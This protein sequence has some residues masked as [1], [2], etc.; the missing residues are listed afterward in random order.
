M[1]MFLIGLTIFVFL[2]YFGMLHLRDRADP[3]YS[4]KFRKIPSWKRKD[5]LF[6]YIW[7]ISMFSAFWF[8]TL[9]ALIIYFCYLCLYKIVFKLEWKEAFDISHII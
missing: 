2:L 1:T 5:E 3:N 8:L 9:P 6:Y 4:G 7:T